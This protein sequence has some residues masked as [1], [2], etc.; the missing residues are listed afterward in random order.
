[1]ATHM[2]MKLPSFK[3]CQRST[4]G[5]VRHRTVPRG[6]VGTSESR[7]SDNS[8]VSTDHAHAGCGCDEISGTEFSAGDSHSKDQP[9]LHY[10]KQKAAT[11]AWQQNRASML[12]AHIECNA[13]PSH[14][15]CITCIKGAEYRCTQCAPW[16][17]FCS[18]CF[19]DAHRS[20]NIFHVG[21]IWEVSHG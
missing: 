14:Q 19:A 3:L 7:K 5:P 17:F 10:I 6:M 1:M 20:V 21:E 2:R 12:R 16:A 15:K 18:S 13:M 9:S 4:H 8:P 11:N